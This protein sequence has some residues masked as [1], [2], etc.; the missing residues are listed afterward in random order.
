MPGPLILAGVLSTTLLAFNVL[1]KWIAQL[2]LWPK[3]V[4]GPPTPNLILGHTM[5]FDS[6]VGI[7]K[8]LLWN[9]QLGPTYCLRGPFLVSRRRVN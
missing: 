9:S 4:P 5:L 2:A 3:H 8:H 1:R 6:P 7:G